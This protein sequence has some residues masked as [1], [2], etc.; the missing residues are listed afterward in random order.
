M[1]DAEYAAQKAR[2]VALI[3]RWP[4]PLGLAWWRITHVYDRD[5]T[6][7]GGSSAASQVTARCDADWRYLYGRLTWYM[8]AVAD[9]EDDELEQVFVHEL[10]HVFLNELRHDDPNHNAAEERVASHL[11]SAFI[12]LRQHC[13]REL[14]EAPGGDQAA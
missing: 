10:M 4:K 2:I 3:E 13:E 12:W 9:L 7:P 11:A 8:Q 14:R 6:P 5:T 1:N